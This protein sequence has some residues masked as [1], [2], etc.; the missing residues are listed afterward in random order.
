MIRDQ[1]AGVY[2][3]QGLDVDISVTV[4]GACNDAAGT[5]DHHQLPTLLVRATQ[6][7]AAAGAEDRTVRLWTPELDSDAAAQL[8]LSIDLRRA[9]A[10]GELVLHYQPQ[11]NAHSHALVGAEALVRWQHRHRGLLGPAQFLPVAEA[12]PI[13]VDLT[14]WVLDDAIRQAAGWY[15]DGHQLP[16]S[17]NLSAR[18]LVHEGLVDHVTA[19]LS[20][21]GL[22]A[23]L[24]TLEVTETAVLTQPERSREVL[25]TLRTFGVKVSLDDFGTGYTSLAMLADLPLDEIKLDRQFVSGALHRVPDAAIA[26]AVASLGRRMD[27]HLVA[28]GVEDHTT[29]RLIAQWGYHT[30]QGFLHSRPIPADQLGQLLTS[31]QQPAGPR[32]P[33]PALSDEQARLAEL[34]QLAVDL[35]GDPFLEHITVLAAEVC[36]AKIALVS[37]VGADEQTFPA[38]HGLGVTSTPRSQSF[39]AHTIV[40]ADMLVVSDA[41]TDPRFADNPLVTGYPSIRHYAGAPLITTAGHVLGAVCVIDETPR[42]LT[43]GQLKALRALADMTVRYLEQRSAHTRDERPSSV[44]SLL[45]IG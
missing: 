25:A 3:L 6:A 42:T 17:V 5:A 16:V 9:V 8:S 20:T 29:G 44:S 26:Q 45:H 7:L 40:S 37:L 13:I 18:L 43:D 30:V 36:G 33:A 39:C 10:A 11:V 28:E 32:P 15:H 35:D 2:C 21:H 19:A 1:A 38:E 24:L 23:R 4:A 31:S 14:Y 41:S 34:R 22:P 12:S 27:L